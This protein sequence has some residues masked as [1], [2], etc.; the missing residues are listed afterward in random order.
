MEKSKKPLIKCWNY[1]V[2]AF[3][4]DDEV[5]FEIHN[6]YY[7]DKG[8]TPISYG[9]PG[10]TIFSESIKGVRKTLKLVKLALE[11]PVLWGDDQFPKEYKKLK[12]K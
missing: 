6:V 10:S 9:E 8:I 11:K 3:L 7:S 4:Q 5:Y 1:R 2:L 12:K